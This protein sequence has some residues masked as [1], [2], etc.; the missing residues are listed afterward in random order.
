M[1]FSH[2]DKETCMRHS[3]IRHL[4]YIDAQCLPNLQANQDGADHVFCGLM[5][6]MFV[7]FGQSCPV[8]NGSFSYRSFG[9]WQLNKGIV[10]NSEIVAMT[11]TDC[12][13]VNTPFS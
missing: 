6:P 3:V 12:L 11:L 1:A 5:Q 7:T 13:R 4:Q 2:R 8:C 10:L 9:T